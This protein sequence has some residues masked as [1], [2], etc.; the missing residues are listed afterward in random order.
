MDITMGFDKTLTNCNVLFGIDPGRIGAA[1][2][3]ELDYLGDSIRLKR[4]KE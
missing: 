2:E 4:A 3:V 1:D